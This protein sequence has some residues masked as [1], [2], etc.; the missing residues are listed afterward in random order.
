MRHP[1]DRPG[2]VDP[3]LVDPAERERLRGLPRPAPHTAAELAALTGLL[4]APRPRTTAVVVGHGRDTASS[5]A[6]AAF[7]ETWE[8]RGGTVLTV[9]DWPETAASWLRA[10][11]RM[12]AE[13]PD[14]WVV[15]AAVPGF[16]QLAR[17]LRHSTSWEPSRTY[18]FGSLGDPRALALAGSGV[19]YGLR[20][21][22]ADGGTW[23]VRGGW[24][25]EFPAR[26]DDDR[27][28][29]AAR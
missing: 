16:V 27:A 14:A 23:E 12:T 3:P 9:V 29:S 2:A 28:R 5:E 21:A 13:S 11:R 15:A 24:I 7:A 25:T 8:A 1:D 18:C 10:A 26:R 17:R 4:T 22:S 19:L 20:G 6:A